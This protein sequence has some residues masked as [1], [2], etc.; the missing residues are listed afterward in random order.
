MIQRL[1]E[2]L[3]AKG[4]RVE[5]RV[6]DHDPFPREHH[7]AVK[8]LNG[9]SLIVKDTEEEQ[10]ELALWCLKEIGRLGW[11]FDLS[12]YIIDRPPFDDGRRYEVELYADGQIG[13]IACGTTMTTAA[14]G[15]L[16][17]LPKEPQD[18]GG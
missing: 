16:C 4:Y 7:W 13:S 2:H 1:I 6:P 18:G 3:K 11:K 5:E 10:P 14:I 9:P 8:V 12:N 15:A 17:S